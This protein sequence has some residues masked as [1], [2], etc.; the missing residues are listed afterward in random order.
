[1]K[2][3][4][5]ALASLLLALPAWATDPVKLTDYFPPPESKGGWRTLLPEKRIPDAAQKAKIRK[6]AGVDWDK[7]AEAW[8]HNL[9]AEGPSM[10]PLARVKRPGSS[11]LRR[12]SRVRV[13]A[14]TPPVPPPRLPWTQPWTKRST[15]PAATCTPDRAGSRR[16]R[17]PSSCRRAGGARS[18]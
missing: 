14:C 12:V 9:R 10:F 15:G 4:H 18:S 1:M 16:R 6:I 3:F 5:V 8:Q 2:T 7:L 11:A 13:R 17:G